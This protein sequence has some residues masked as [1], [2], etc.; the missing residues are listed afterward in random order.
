MTRYPIFHCRKDKLQQQDFIKNIWCSFY[1]ECLDEAAIS[2]TF[3]DCSQC[4]NIANDQKE[5][6]KVR[7]L[8]CRI[9]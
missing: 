4:D 3:M 2:D 6:W 8:Y 5:E 1:E 9:V 7:Y